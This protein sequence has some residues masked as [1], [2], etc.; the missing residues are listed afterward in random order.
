[1]KSNAHHVLILGCG[2]LAAALSF[3]LGAKQVQRLADDSGWAWPST[4]K[5]DSEKI[6]GIRLVLAVGPNAGIPQ[7]IRWHRDARE[8][9]LARRVG[10]MLF[11]MSPSLS[12]ELN[13]R[14]VFG[15]I[16]GDCASFREWGPDLVMVDHTR[17]LSELVRCL[18][19]LETLP[20]SSWRR[21]LHA[22][23]CLPRLIEAI[24]NRNMAEL[25][26][27]LEAVD[28][29]DWDAICFSG[30]HFGSAHAWANRTRNWLAGV[31][32]GVT[33]DWEEGLVLF[34]P[35]CNRYPP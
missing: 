7:W 2:P 27:C 34:S 18:D 12:E 4:T 23:S 29:S 17:T 32:A 20:E 26:L 31:T 11:G 24:K 14:D 25:V 22:A 33:P 10:C 6:E 21:D 13:D 30:K 3:I 35:L 9:P 19:E 1:M 8:C 16:G 15:R 5:R 28:A